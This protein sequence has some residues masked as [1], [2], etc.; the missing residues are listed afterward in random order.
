[1]ILS[2]NGG[3]HHDYLERA[4]S[5]L[6]TVKPTCVEAERTFSSAGFSLQ[7]FVTVWA[8]KLRAHCAS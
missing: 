2:E 5:F 4:Y 7:K 6:M 3:T 1:M 8:I